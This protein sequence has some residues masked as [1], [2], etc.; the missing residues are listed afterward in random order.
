M[1]TLCRSGNGLVS[2]V[3]P[4]VQRV[5]RGFQLG[6][7]LAANSESA[8]A[9]SQKADGG[10]RVIVDKNLKSIRPYI[11]AFVASGP[12]LDEPGLIDLIQM[13]EKLCGNYGRKRLSIAMGVYRSGQI[14]YPI[15]YIAAHPDKTRFTPLGMEKELS[16]R[17]ILTEHPKG[18]E[19]G[20]IISEF[21]QFPYLKD[22]NGKALSMPP[23]INSAQLGAVEVGDTDLFIE[24]TGTEIDTLLLACSITTMGLMAQLLPIMAAPFQFATQE[25]RWASLVQPYIP[26]WLAPDPAVVRGFFVGLEKGESIPWGAWIRPLAGWLLFLVPAGFVMIATMVIL[27]KQWVERENL[28]FPLT[29]LPAAMSEAPTGRKL[30]GP[31]FR[32]PGMWIGFA[33]P[34]LAERKSCSTP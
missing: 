33:S 3:S 7:L 14:K 17:S 9:K 21:K 34:P 11:A 16:L 23:I 27:R 10:K 20:G 15:H 32:N 19:F 4:Q 6:R 8:A 25:N 28:L 12:A 2:V 24:L 31:F 18:I 30:M 5:A 13:Q 1:T 22:G 26:K 29:V